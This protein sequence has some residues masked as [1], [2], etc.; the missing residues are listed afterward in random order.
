MQTW[1]GVNVDTGRPEW[2]KNGVDGDK[3]STY[4]EATKVLQGGS[5]IPTYS[6]GFSTHIDFYGFFI[7]ASILVAGGNKVYESWV[8]QTMHAGNT[9]MQ[10]YN[11]QQK[12][13]NRWQK[14]GDITDV[15]KM[16][17]TTTGDNGTSTSSRFLYDGDYIRMKDLS[18]GYQVPKD[19]LKNT[20][21][22]GVTFSLRGSNLFTWVK[23]DRLVYDPETRANGFTE[24]ITD[25]KSVV[26]GNSVVFRVYL[27]GGRII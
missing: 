22:D 26:V 16:L 2:F 10:T 15:P 17:L 9:S 3:T 24:L 21:L 7:D 25:R 19:F 11:G 1:A 8:G 14:P 20:G 12:L 18:F 23:D 4:S 13:L 27:G 6:G 5:A